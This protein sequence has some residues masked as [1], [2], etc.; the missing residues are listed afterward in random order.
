MSLMNFYFEWTAK[1]KIIREM[2]P[3]T[4]VQGSP[5]ELECE[6]SDMSG[7]VTWLKEGKPF[8][9]DERVR[10]QNGSGGVRLLTIEKAD[11]EDAAEYT[12]KFADL[13]T[14]AKLTVTG[15]L[16]ILQYHAVFMLWSSVLMGLQVP[17]YLFSTPLGEI[18]E[19]IQDC[20]PTMV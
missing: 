11:F 6:I 18:T 2:A 3:A 10:A 7:E 17:W 14:K 12:C 19:A 13:T 5:T 4:V 15:E 16:D 9:L 1:P 8:V 20:Q